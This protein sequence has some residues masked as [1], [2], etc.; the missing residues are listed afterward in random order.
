MTKLS[1]F[2][3]NKDFKMSLIFIVVSVHYVLLLVTCSG[4]ENS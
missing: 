1:I 2:S 3:V 4:L